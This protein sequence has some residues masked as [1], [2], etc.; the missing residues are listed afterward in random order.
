MSSL[1]YH[2]EPSCTPREAILLAWPGLPSL[3]QMFQQAQA[4]DPPFLAGTLTWWYG[5]DQWQSGECPLLSLCP[6]C[7]GSNGFLFW[8]HDPNWSHWPENHGLALFPTLI[9]WENPKMW[10]LSSDVKVRCAKEL[11]GH[12]HHSRSKLIPPTTLQVKARADV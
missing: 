4:L 9:L 11:P 7:N 5:F 12:E 2:L 3:L 8:S 1:T 10:L 6:K